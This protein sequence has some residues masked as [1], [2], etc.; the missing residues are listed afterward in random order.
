MKNNNETGYYYSDYSSLAVLNGLINLR[1]ENRRV[2]IIET[3]EIKTVKLVYVFERWAMI[4]EEVEII[5]F[6]KPNE[7]EILPIDG[8]ENINDIKPLSEELIH[9]TN[10]FSED[11]PPKSLEQYEMEQEELHKNFSENEEQ[12]DSEMGGDYHYRELAVGK[13]IIYKPSEVIEEYNRFGHELKAHV[14]SDGIFIGEISDLYI[15]DPHKW[16]IVSFKEKISGQGR[17][18]Y[19]KK[20]Y[21]WYMKKDNF[22]ILNKDDNIEEVIAELKTKDYITKIEPKKKFKITQYRPAFFSGFEN[23]KV[24][25]D[26]VE[27]LLNIDFVKGW[28]TDPGFFQ[29]SLSY[30][31]RWDS[32]LKLMAEF[33]NENKMEWWVIGFISADNYDEVI[34]MLPKFQ[35]REEE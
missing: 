7:V 6:Y 21:L 30:D 9:F 17:F 23:E 10:K 25:F 26:T 1:Y 22:R 24:E 5:W 27:E 28:S 4:I 35:P 11:K 18:N 3:G 16:A 32:Q 33:K 8:S 31:I 13:I 2:K 20:G 19:N 29:Y 12:L 14:N 34:H 15:C